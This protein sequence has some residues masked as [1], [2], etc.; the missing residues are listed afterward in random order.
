MELMLFFGLASMTILTVL[1]SIATI[2]RASFGV[3]QRFGRRTGRILSE[4]INVVLPFGIERIELISTELRTT[5]VTVRFFGKD[6]LEAILTGSLQWRASFA[7][8]DE[9]GRNRFVEMSEQT[10]ADGITDAVESVCANLA[11][12]ETA[13]TFI[14][15]RQA[16]E[17]CINCAVRFPVPPHEERRL[18]PAEWIPFY[19]SEGTA[20]RRLLEKGGGGRFRDASPLE[21]RYG[22]EVATFAITNI[23][24]S[25]ATKQALEK[26]RQTLATLEAVDEQ[27]LRAE[28]IA[29]RLR[30]EQGL[31]PVTAVNTA[32]ILLGLAENRIIT[33]EGLDKAGLAEL[34]RRVQQ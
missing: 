28:K 21:A 34:L 19:G 10:I 5:P 16:V 25:D 32:R 22:I 30:E 33:L 27:A 20:L 9:Y 12:N 15:E 23:T 2:P 31:D 18:A 13:E 24:F 4:G 6:N 14:R 29:Q 8:A 26:K 17:D 11:G 7:I 1:T 3:V